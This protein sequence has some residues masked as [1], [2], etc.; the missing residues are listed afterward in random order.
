M[1]KIRKT[2]NF[3]ICKQTY[4][5]LLTPLDLVAPL[6]IFRSLIPTT[7][8]KNE[9]FFFYLLLPEIDE[10]NQIVYMCQIFSR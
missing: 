7:F 6:S 8:K 4:F 2:H 3:A 9:S 1:L 10:G 5:I